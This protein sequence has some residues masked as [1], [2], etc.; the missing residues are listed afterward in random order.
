MHVNAR[1]LIERIENGELQLLIQ[2]RNKPYEGRPRFEVPGGRLE[3]FESLVEA[4]RREVREETGLE[5]S[6]IEG[7]E[8][9]IETNGI[10]TNVECIRPFA[11]YQTLRGP[12]DSVGFYFRCQAEGQL[13][14]AGDEADHPRWMAVSEI[15]RLMNAD[16]EQFSFVDRAGLAFYFEQPASELRK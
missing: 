13:L 9:R 1:A 5:L 7:Q 14:E 16:P 6:N 2:V 8:T 4:L 11:A 3:E 10:D 15:A 12:V